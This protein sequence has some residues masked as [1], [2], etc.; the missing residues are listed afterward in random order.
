M[1]ESGSGTFVPSPEVLQK[2]EEYA[3]LLGQFGSDSQPARDF[4][5]RYKHLPMF[6]ENANDL[7]RLQ[8]EDEG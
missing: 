1:N 5:L 4:Y 2:L 7:Y 3:R 6:F 8:R